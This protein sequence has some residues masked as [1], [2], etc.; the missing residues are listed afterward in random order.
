MK[1]SIHH[2]EMM[3]DL[4]AAFLQLKNNKEQFDISSKYVICGASTGGHLAMIYTYTRN[5]EIKCVGNIF[6]PSNIRDWD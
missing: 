1:Q 4:H 3:N 5:S 6:G 2:E